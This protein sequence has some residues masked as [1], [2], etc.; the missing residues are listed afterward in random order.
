MA[1]C[2]FNDDYLL[3]GND[4]CVDITRSS[5]TVQVPCT[6]YKTEQYTVK[7]P[8]QVTEQ[9]PRTVRYTDFEIRTKSV[10]Y[11]FNRSERRTS[12]ETQSYQVPVTNI[13]TRMVP[14]TKKVAKTVMVPKTVY[15]D[16]TSQEPKQYTTTKMETRTRQIPVPYFVNIPETRYRTVTEQVPVQRTKVEIDTVSKTVYDTQVRNTWVPETKMCSKSIPVY[17][18]RSKPPAPCRKEYDYGSGQDSG[19]YGTGIA[20]YVVDQSTMSG[21]GFADYSAYQSTE[22]YD[23]GSIVA[24]QGS[25]LGNFG[26]DASV[27][28]SGDCAVVDPAIDSGIAGNSGMNAAACGSGD[29]AVVDPAIDSGIADNFMSIGTNGDGFI[30]SY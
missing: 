20:G 5:R 21:T 23:N 16:V 12:M 4:D 22:N 26:M 6:F 3:N 25:V 14:V 7:V 9:R 19:D 30:R 2:G 27:C 11:T 13:Q 29:C 28:G 24:E 15:V 17:N 8:R 1:V 10:P 18:V